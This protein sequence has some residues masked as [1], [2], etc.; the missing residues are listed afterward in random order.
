MARVLEDIEDDLRFIARL[1]ELWCV[2]ACGA[3]RRCGLV[4]GVLVWF[5]VDSG[6]TL[7]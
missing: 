2:E 1:K 5:K 6:D 4:S 3:S 7:W